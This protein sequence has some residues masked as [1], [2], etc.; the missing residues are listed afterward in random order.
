MRVTD[1]VLTPCVAAVLAALSLACAPA[2]GQVGFDEPEVDTDPAAPGDPV[3]GGRLVDDSGREIRPS[4]GL[5]RRRQA[6]RMDSFV[7]RYSESQAPRRDHPS[8]N[9][10]AA[11]ETRLAVRNGMVVTIDESR[12]GDRLITVPM[13]EI[14]EQGTAISRAALEQMGTQIRDWLYEQGFLARVEPS[15]P[16]GAELAASPVALDVLIDV[17]PYPVGELTAR[18]LEEHPDHPP[19]EELF[20]T[21]VVLSL[22]PGGWIAEDT[23]FETRRVPIG[24]LTNLETTD[25]YFSALLAVNEA[26][27]DALLDRGL[28]GVLVAADP[29]AIRLRDLEDN[30]PVDDDSLDLVI[31]TGVVREVRTLAFGARVGD[32]VRENNPVHERI[33]ERSP[34]RVWDGEGERNDLLRRDEL[35]EYLLR[36][37]RV[38]GRRVD[39]AIS[40]AD[41]GGAQLD[42]LI[43]ERQPVLAYVQVSNTGTESTDEIRYRAG[44]NITQLAN[45]DD[46]LTLDYITAGFDESQAVISTY[47]SR[48]FGADTLRWRIDGNYSEFTASD[49]G[50]AEENFEG[51][52][53]ALGAELIWNFY[54]DGDLFLDAFAGARFQ[55]VDVEN[56]GIGVQGDSDFL[57]PR[58]GVRVERD[59]KTARTFGTVFVETNLPGTAGTEDADEL[60]RLGRLFVDDDWFV[61]KWN[62]SHSFYLEPILNRESWSDLQTPSSSTLAHE[63]ALGIRGQYAPDDRLI[64]QEQQ[65]AGGLYTVRGYPESESAGDTVYIGSVEYRF[66]VP[67]SLAYSEDAGSLFGSPFRWRP[68]EPFGEADWDLV[69]KGF[70]DAGRTENTDRLPFESDETLVGAGVGVEFSFRRRFTARVDWG[71]A[72]E[73]TEDGSVESGDNEVHFSVTALF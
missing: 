6:A 13:S 36:L 32:E 14:G 39:A 8:I 30:R 31:F 65:V 59:R 4:S 46:V 43:S 2:L 38:T 24:Q 41:R 12:A 10:I 27:R 62:V 1:R 63:I 61:A 56:V 37:N 68:Q 52:S 58:L 35:D 73:E 54:Q 64:P 55:H 7:V 49:V 9:D 47:E 11:L 70:L 57:I 20:R 16:P 60:S 33:K 40:P 34:L 45:T 5:V 44:L 28:I 50:L 53:Y 69:L 72:L 19:I 71:F 22:A 66:H 17:G 67:K 15:V 18:Y 25:F 42:F 3:E 23:R 26:I 51:E 48:F 21:E 29:N